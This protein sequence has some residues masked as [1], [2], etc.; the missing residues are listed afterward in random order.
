[1][2]Q[3]NVPRQNIIKK[4]NEF[5]YLTSPK[6]ITAVNYTAADNW[7]KKTRGGIGVFFSL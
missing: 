3:W 4:V 1:M 7:F 6:D 2:A 5:Y